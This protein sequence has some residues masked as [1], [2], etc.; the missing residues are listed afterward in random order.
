MEKTAK[1]KKLSRGIDSP[2]HRCAS[3][4]PRVIARY[5]AIPNKQ[6]RSV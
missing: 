3:S 6:V 4:S 1:Q 5:E 2:R